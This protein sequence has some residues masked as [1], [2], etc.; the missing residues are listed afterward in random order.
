MSPRILPGAARYAARVST[1]ERAR[2]LR[3]AAPVAVLV[4]LAA[5][6]YLP[7]LSAGFVWD[8]DAYVTENPT[9]RTLAGLRDIWLSPR[10]TPQYYPLV[11]TFFWL[12][13]RLW[14]LTAAGYHA[15]NVALH[16]LCAVLA[17]RTLRRLRV[18]GAFWA[19]ALFA[20]HPVMVESVAWVTERKNVLSLA[21]ALGALLAYLR[22]DDL[23]EETAPPRPAA[24]ALALV[25]FACALL[26]KTVACSL[27]AVIL[28]LAWWK[29]G[30]IRARDLAP[31]VPF[32]ALGLAGGLHTAWLEADSVGARGAEFALG[33]LDR[34]AIAGRALWF[35]AA[36]LVWPHPLAFFYDRWEIDGHDPLQWVA[37][38]G[39]VALAIALF[40][41][42][43]RL[44]R[45]PLAALLIYA[46]VLVPALG[47]LD[48]Y[49][50]RYSFVAD[51]FQYHAS[52]AA[53]AAAAAC[54]AALARARPR[55]R[56][57]VAAAGVAILAVFGVLTLRQ[58]RVYESFETL[59]RH[60]IAVSPSAW[61][62]YSNLAQHLA[63]R[64]RVEEAVE[65]A[66][67]GARAAPRVAE[68]H[69]T[70]GAMRTVRATALAAGPE[71]DATV[72]AAIDAFR[73]A[74]HIEPGYTETHYNLAFALEVA[75]RPAEAIEHYR[76][77]LEVH[78]DD[79]PAVV[80]IARSWVTLGRPEDAEPWIARARALGAV[81]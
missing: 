59:F 77:V 23:E 27:P 35:Y 78:P 65:I 75:G 38:A 25:L 51:H 15:V 74:L 39:V 55:A 4:L 5:V 37:P 61:G 76:R 49:P 41:A 43:A 73:A 60:T 81:P 29:R 66:E 32:F 57:A 10:A 44:G 12:E 40:A 19:A 17:W 63:E 71:R 69:N 68:V 28:V 42:R 36:K 22:F 18:G 1:S 9:L 67:R 14:E 47:F 8:D 48:V 26:S 79:A 56:H 33:P 45:G 72:G 54:G 2:T 30:R 52:L 16:A 80:G 70:L 20:V 21:F 64:G 46:G 11:H 24:Y 3:A 50:F 53:I 31:L 62:A 6:V 34:V 13:Y 58:A 7:A